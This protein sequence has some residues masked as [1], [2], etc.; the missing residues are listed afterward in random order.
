PYRLVLTFELNEESTLSVPVAACSFGIYRY[1][2]GTCAKLFG[3]V[4]QLRLSIYDWRNPTDGV[5]YECRL[6]VTILRFLPG[7]IGRIVKTICGEMRARNRYFLR[8][9][10]SGITPSETGGKP[11][12]VHTISVQAVKCLF[13]FSPVGVHEARSSRSVI[14]VCWSSMPNPLDR[15]LVAV[16]PGC[17]YVAEASSSDSR[18]QVQATSVRRGSSPRSVST[19]VRI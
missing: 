19:L 7:L 18:I 17:R 14:S 12:N 1:R 5:F 8:I 6:V 9:G 15:T 4:L 11:A 13:K 2:T 16:P 10:L 3:N